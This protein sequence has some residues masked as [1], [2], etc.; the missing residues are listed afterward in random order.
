MIDIHS[1][2][3]KRLPAF[4]QVKK[5]IECYKISDLSLR[6]TVNKF[7]TDTKKSGKI[8]FFSQ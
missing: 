5:L 8:F 4:L 1:K 6:Q 2:I 7:M 3:D